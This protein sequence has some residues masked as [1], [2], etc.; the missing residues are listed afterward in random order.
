MTDT[1]RHSFLRGLAAAA[2]VTAIALSTHILAA[3]L[4]IGRTVEPETVMIVLRA[5]A[6]AE[7]ELAKVIANHWTTARQFDLVRETPHVTLRGTD[8]HGVYF[9]DVFTWKDADTPDHAPAPILAAWADMNR[10]TE[11]RG[12]RPGLEITPVK[13]VAQ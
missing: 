1:H 6:G 13:L 2:W 7:S 10:L 3:G 8:D 12:G 4:T 5:K 9:V 11:A